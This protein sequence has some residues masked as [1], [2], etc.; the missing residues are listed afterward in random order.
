MFYCKQTALLT[1]LISPGDSSKDI[2]TDGETKIDS[3]VTRLL[4]KDNFVEIVNLI[5]ENICAQG[6]SKMSGELG[7]RVSDCMGKQKQM[8]KQSGNNFG[9]WM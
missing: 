6:D 9:Y 5:T 2:N 7:R 4:E 8:Q 1:E 3:M